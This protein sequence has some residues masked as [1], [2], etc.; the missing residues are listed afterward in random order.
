VIALVTA[1]KITRKKIA[2]VFYVLVFAKGGRFLTH[3]CV[4]FLSEEIEVR[5]IVSNKKNFTASQSKIFEKCYY[6]KITRSSRV[7]LKSDNFL[8]WTSW[9]TGAAPRAVKSAA[10]STCTAAC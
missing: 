3:F 2:N 1:Q 9:G 10:S 6:K 8:S 5:K 4:I 7:I